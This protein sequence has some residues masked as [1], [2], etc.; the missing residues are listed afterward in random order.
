MSAVS[1]PS[2]SKCGEPCASCVR[3]SFEEEKSAFHKKWI[4]IFKAFAKHLGLP[5]TAYDLSSNKGGPAIMGEVSFHTDYVYAEVP[6]RFKI[7]EEERGVPA[8]LVR[9]VYSRKDYS[10]GVNQWISCSSFDGD[11]KP[12]LELFRAMKK[13][14]SEG[15]L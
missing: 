15:K 8:V 6:G 12:A 3:T 2:C 14:K 4:A 1:S 10:G 5:K 13:N 11:M 9:A 7:D